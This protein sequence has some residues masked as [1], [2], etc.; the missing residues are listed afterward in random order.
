VL[1]SHLLRRG[2]QGIEKALAVAL[3]V[4]L[5]EVRREVEQSARS[6]DP[7][8]VLFRR[9]EACEFELWG[10]VLEIPSGEPLFESIPCSW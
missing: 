2:I 7:P 5:F 10:A 4:R 3:G 1:P 6:P 8:D 9:E